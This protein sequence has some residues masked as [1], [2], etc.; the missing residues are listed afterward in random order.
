MLQAVGILKMWMG[1]STVMNTVAFSGHI[2]VI[3]LAGAE[4]GEVRIHTFGDICDGMLTSDVILTCS[5]HGEEMPAWFLMY[6][7]E[8][9]VGGFPSG[10]KGVG[11]LQNCP[12]AAW[13]T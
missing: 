1:F 10:W 11:M 13:Q 3:V 8:V 4:S 2:R 12:F 5:E 7:A 6:K 9:H